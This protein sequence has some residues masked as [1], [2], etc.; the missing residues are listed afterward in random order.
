MS[1]KHNG[2]LAL[3]FSH[4][5]FQLNRAM[6]RQLEKNPVYNVGEKKSQNQ[7]FKVCDFQNHLNHLHASSPLARNRGWR[8][9][10]MGVHSCFLTFQLLVSVIMGTGYQLLLELF[11]KELHY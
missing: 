2:V 1:L 5:H 8:K 4:I 9:D 6:K 7:F 10:G 3:S 11:Q